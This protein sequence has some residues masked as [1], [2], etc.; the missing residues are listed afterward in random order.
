D[1]GEGVGSWKLLFGAVSDTAS[2]E[3]TPVHSDTVKLTVPGSTQKKENVNY[4]AELTWTL[5]A[6][7]EI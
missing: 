1:E 2:T 7:P 5:L 6:T 3:S 4:E